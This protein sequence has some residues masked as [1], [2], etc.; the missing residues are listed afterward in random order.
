[1]LR[2]TFKMASV[3]EL[4]DVGISDQHSGRLFAL[5]FARRLCVVAATTAIILT[6]VVVEKSAPVLRWQRSLLVAFSNVTL[7]ILFLTSL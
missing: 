1:M 3:E 4:K 5:I 2:V 7:V 6:R